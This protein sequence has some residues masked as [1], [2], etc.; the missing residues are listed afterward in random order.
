MLLHLPDEPDGPVAFGTLLVT[1]DSVA[2]VFLGLD[3]RYV[4]SHHSYQQLLL[5]ALRAGQRHGA[6]QVL[7]GMSADLQKSRF[8][9]RRERRWG[10]VQAGETF[11]ADVLAHLA[12]GMARV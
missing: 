3:R 7:Y 12:A 10:Y 5:Q 2:T 6:E 4:A 8:G 9:A 1:A 11:S